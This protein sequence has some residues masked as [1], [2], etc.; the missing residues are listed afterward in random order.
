MSNF[1]YIALPRAFKEGAD[2]RILNTFRPGGYG[3]EYEMNFRP[4]LPNAN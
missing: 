2:P 3:Y 4:V 1:S